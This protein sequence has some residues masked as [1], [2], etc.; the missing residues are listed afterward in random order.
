MASVRHRVLLPTFLSFSHFEKV[1]VY[2]R[3]PYVS[4]DDYVQLVIH[5]Q[6]ISQKWQFVCLCEDMVLSSFRNFDSKCL[7]KVKVR[8]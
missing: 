4:T 2:R 5:F 1:T 7:F 6:T 3:C 8:S